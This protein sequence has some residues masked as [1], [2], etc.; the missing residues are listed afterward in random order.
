MAKQNGTSVE[1]AINITNQLVLEK[2]AGSSNTPMTNDPMLAEMNQEAA[3][4]AQENVGT[5][6]NTNF[7]GQ[8]IAQKNSMSNP[9]QNPAASHQDPITGSPVPGNSST[10]FQKPAFAGGDNQSDLP[11]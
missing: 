3:K 8:N 10:P 2:Q 1:E 9:F 7:G 4:A 6:G 5:Y 11:F